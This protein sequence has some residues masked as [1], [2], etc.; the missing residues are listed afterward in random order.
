MSKKVSR[1]FPKLSELPNYEKENM[2]RTVI[3]TSRI[4]EGI[5][6]K[7]RRQGIEYVLEGGKYKAV[8]RVK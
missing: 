6:E 2:V 3:D 4:V 8:K 7:H 5:V 1:K